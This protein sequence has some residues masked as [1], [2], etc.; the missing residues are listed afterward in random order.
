MVSTGIVYGIVL[1][2]EMSQLAD[3]LADAA[4]RLA[5]CTDRQ[6][7]GSPVVSTGWGAKSDVYGIVLQVEMSQLA[8]WLADAA[9]RLAD[10][11]DRP[12][13]NSV[14]AEQRLGQLLTLVHEFG[15]RKTRFQDLEKRPGLDVDSVAELQRQ[16]ERTSADCH[17]SLQVPCISRYFT[18]S[19]GSLQEL[20]VRRIIP[21]ISS[22]TPPFV[23][24]LPSLPCPSLP[25]IEAIP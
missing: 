3:W 25:R 16:F 10:C 19:G 12:T 4:R 5:D 1:Q 21:P 2:V 11:T 13:V 24:Y 14:V 17:D 8:D 9:R 18:N 6:L 22:Q 23:T 20:V 7:G 15:A